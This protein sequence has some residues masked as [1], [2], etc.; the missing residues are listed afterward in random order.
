MGIPSQ[1]SNGNQSKSPCPTVN[2][3]VEKQSNQA[4]KTS[5]L[6]KVVDNSKALSRMHPINNTVN[7]TMNKTESQNRSFDTKTPKPATR[8]GDLFSNNNTMPYTIV[9]GKKI[10]HN[11]KFDNIIINKSKLTSTIVSN[12][13]RLMNMKPNYSNNILNTSSQTANREVLKS[14]GNTHNNNVFH[15]ENSGFNPMLNKENINNLNH[16]E[17]KSSENKLERKYSFNDENSVVYHKKS[18]STLTHNSSSNLI[19]GMITKT[20]KANDV[21]N[22][23]CSKYSSFSN[24]PPLAPNLNR[25]KFYDMHKN[26]NRVLNKTDYKDIYANGVQDSRH[27]KHEY[28]TNEMTKSR[29]TNHSFIRKADNINSSERNINHVFTNH[30]SPVSENDRLKSI[31]S[32]TQNNAPQEKSSPYSIGGDSYR[33]MPKKSKSLY[34]NDFNKH[35]NVYTNYPQNNAPKDPNLPMYMKYKLIPNQND[36]SFYKKSL[37]NNSPQVFSSRQLYN[38]ENTVMR[39]ANSSMATFLNGTN[40]TGKT[41]YM[42]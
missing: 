37:S 14:I 34:D 17:N 40:A 7:Y 22:S 16:L 6:D 13:A 36:N 42:N 2:T 18:S 12:S 19:P 11:E 23:F 28:I 21:D 31:L 41:V 33:A 38:D 26:S 8:F 39:K 4:D 1:R 25:P 30:G 9:D 10:S 15:R 3:N 32:F 24:V 5:L 35:K 29:S 20:H 27:N